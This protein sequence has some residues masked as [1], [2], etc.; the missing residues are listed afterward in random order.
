M[1]G[2]DVGDHGN[3][4]F[5]AAGQPGDLTGAAHPHLDHHGCISSSRFQNGERNTHIIVVVAFTGADG[6]EGR[7]GCTDQFTGGGLPRR[8]SH[9]H[10]RMAEGTAVQQCQ[11][12]I[13]HQGVLNA[14]MQHPRRH[15]MLPTA[16]HNRG[17]DALVRQLGE[18]PVP[19]E[20]F[21]DQGHKEITGAELTAVG[22]NP[23]ERYRWFHATSAGSAP[24]IAQLL[25]Q[26]G[27]AGGTLLNRI[28]PS[29]TR[30]ERASRRSLP[31][32]NRNSL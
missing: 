18:K 12:L 10:Q 26:Q 19:I 31:L 24:E 21:P 15:G 32:T 16:G 1:G 9:R 7:Q 13:R 14:P 22:A 23:A 28:M 8:T 4:G 27:H 6:T 2:A 30:A 29:P 25:Q 11:L 17:I 3:I 20:P 5:A